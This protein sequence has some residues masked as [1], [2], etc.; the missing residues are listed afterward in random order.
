MQAPI[1]KLSEFSTAVI[2]L[3]WKFRTESINKASPSQRKNTGIIK[4]V[5]HSSFYNA[6]IS[7]PD[8][9]SQ[10]NYSF[11]VLSSAQLSQKQWSNL[12]LPP[13]ATMEVTSLTTSQAKGSWE[14]PPSTSDS[15][16]F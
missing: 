11:P 10:V 14:S 6:V 2:K 13:A 9:K 4:A 12:P 8:T 16:V 3:H 5:K 15:E 1:V 7:H